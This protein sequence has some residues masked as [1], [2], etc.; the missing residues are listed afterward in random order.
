M[1]LWQAVAL[2][3]YSDIIDKILR[4]CL[5]I[6]SL[7]SCL[8]YSGIVCKNDCYGD[9]FYPVFLL[10]IVWKNYSDGLENLENSGNFILPNL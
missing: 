5:E 8:Q 2:P 9:S 7:P 6:A 4:H 3:K 10:Y 1:K